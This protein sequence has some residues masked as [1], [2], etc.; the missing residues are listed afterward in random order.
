MVAP[1]FSTKEFETAVNK[2]AASFITQLAELA[3]LSIREMVV[4]ALQQPEQRPRRRRVTNLFDPARALRNGLGPIVND[5]E[6]KCIAHALSK[7]GG[8]VTYA[9]EALR[10]TRQSLQRKIRRLKVP[11]AIQPQSRKRERRTQNR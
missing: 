5:F 8:N 4:H 11:A 1:S 6:R 3:R 2:L 7:H 9:A 10:M